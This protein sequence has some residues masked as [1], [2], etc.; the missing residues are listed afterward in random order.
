MDVA[1]CTLLIH[2]AKTDEKFDK[3]EKKL[4]EEYLLSL[5]KNKEYINHL[6]KYCE[7]KEKNSVEIS[8]NDKRN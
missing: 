1:I 3:Q 8:R 7:I 2:T 6:F 5:G 4:I